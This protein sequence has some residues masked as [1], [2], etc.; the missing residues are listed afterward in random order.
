MKTI[1]F[2]TTK[3]MM[4]EHLSFDAEVASTLLN[5]SLIK[6]DMNTFI[7]WCKKQD[8]DTK[9]CIG[10]FFDEEHCAH[11]NVYVAMREQ[12]VEFSSCKKVVEDRCKVLGKPFAVYVIRIAFGTDKEVIIKKRV[13]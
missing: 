13:F 12:G 3:E 7:G 4:L 1:E 8:E 10:K 6:A 11:I 2:T 5:S 9:A